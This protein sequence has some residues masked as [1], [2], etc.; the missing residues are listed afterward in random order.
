M[1]RSSY[2]VTHPVSAVWP[3]RPAPLGATWNGQGVNFAIFSEHAERVELCL[4]DDTG[5]RQT[6]RIELRDRTD[7]VWH[8]Y[9]P[10]ARPGL[11]YGYRVHGPYRPELGHR[12]NAHKLVIDPYSRDI[13]GK[14]RWSDAHYGY[15]L[16]HRREDLSFDRRENAGGMPKCRV[17]DSA[18]SWGDDARPLVPWQDTVIYEL[19]VG[20]FTKLNPLVPPALRGSFAGL[21]CPPVID[22][23]RRLGV[24]SIELMPVHSFA[25]DRRL[26]AQGL[27][28]YW[29]YNTLGYFA[30]EQ[31]FC[32]S[33]NI[34]E[35]KVMVKSLHAAGLEVI[36]DVVYNHT[37]EGNQCGP[38]LCFRGVDNAVYYRLKPDEP[39]YYVDF[40]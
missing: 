25:D 20:G 37:A 32:A 15:T 38:T 22:Y 33:G 35:F 28:N 18:Y 8:C 29:G 14:L 6:Q 7:Q 36:L 11:L 17:I 30:P 12:F 10:E 9:L 13:V 5:R 3:G 40:T 39:R 27:R 19:H 2:S 21:S 26:V 24:T 31:R 23:L 1:N 34:N 4:F 16:G